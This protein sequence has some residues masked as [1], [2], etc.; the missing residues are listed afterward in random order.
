[1]ITISLL[2]ITD[3]Y[4]EEYIALSKLNLGKDIVED[5][6]ILR[7]D[8]SDL[9]TK[10]FIQRYIDK[11]SEEFHICSDCFCG[12]EPHVIE[13]IHDELDCSPIETLCDGYVCCYCGK[14]YDYK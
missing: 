4:L 5:L 3:E 1:M 14:E 8:V 7:D 6:S 11:Y 10:Q 2:E 12:L 9:K 13:E